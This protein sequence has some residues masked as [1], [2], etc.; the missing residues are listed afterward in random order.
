[1]KNTRMS[2]VAALLLRAMRERAGIAND[3]MI[4][5]NIRSV[6]WQSLTFVGERHEFSLSMAPPDGAAAA[7]RLIDNLAAAEW[8]LPGHLVADIVMVA[9][10]QA[11]DGTVTVAFE[12]LTL[13]H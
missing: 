3:R 10:T 8:S 2:A 6:D 13:N 12:A 5:G 7:A 4:V 9:H 11:D 1:M